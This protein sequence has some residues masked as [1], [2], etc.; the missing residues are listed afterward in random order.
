MKKSE[1]TPLLGKTPGPGREEHIRQK[2]LLA[3]N[4]GEKVWDDQV[5][6]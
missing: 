1:A 6:P 3:E 2:M 5:Q 4:P